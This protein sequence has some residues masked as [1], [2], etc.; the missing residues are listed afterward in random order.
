M[1]TSYI[2]SAEQRRDS[3]LCDKAYPGWKTGPHH[4]I[5][6]LAINGIVLR[7]SLLLMNVCFPSML[8]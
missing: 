8:V 3:S 4:N 5:S 1:R 6:S 2:E 7:K